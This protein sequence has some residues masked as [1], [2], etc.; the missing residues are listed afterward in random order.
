M[1]SSGPNRQKI[2]K[3]AKKK[4]VFRIF[5]YR[6]LGKG[7]SWRRSMTRRHEKICIFYPL[8]W[9]ELEAEKLFYE[10]WWNFFVAIFGTFDLF[11][12]LFWP[13]FPNFSFFLVK[14]SS[15]CRRRNKI[16]V[17]HERIS[18]RMMYFSFQQIWLANMWGFPV[19]NPLL[20]NWISHE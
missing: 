14:S 5:H 11:F 10:F 19:G 1:W 12:W 15:Q 3:N 8:R 4:E 6:N 2:L 17:W 20:R 16:L 18:T 7:L 9:P 13:F